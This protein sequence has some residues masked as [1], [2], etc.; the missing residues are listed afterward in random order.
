MIVD[1][2]LRPIPISRLVL[3]SAAQVLA[4]VISATVLP[5]RDP[6][7]SKLTANSP[8]LSNEVPKCV[9]NSDWGQGIHTHDCHTVINY[10]YDYYKNYFFYPYEF[11]GS[12]AQPPE[13]KHVVRTPIKIHHGI[14]YPMF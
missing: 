9:Y 4:A 11:V 6:S 5:T 3:V 2:L 7:L 1:M 14:T 12:E 13:G 10:M 8:M